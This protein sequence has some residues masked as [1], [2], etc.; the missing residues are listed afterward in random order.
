M[1]PFAQFPFVGQEHESVFLAGILTALQRRQ[2]ESA[3]LFG[4]S[5]PAQRNGK[6]LLVESIGIIATGRIPAAAG[7][8][9]EGEEVRKAITSTLKE[10][11]LVA[12]LDNVVYP[13]DS[14]DLARALTAPLY[15]DRLLGTNSNACL[16]T[17]VMWTATGNNLTFKGDMSMRALLCRIDANL[18]R[19]E[20]RS[21]RIADLRA[22]LR[23][24][25]KQLVA[26]A[27]TILRAYQVAG[28]PRQDV[29]PWGGFDDWSRE[30]REPLS[31]LGMADPCS[32]R[33]QI[34]TNDPE[35]E[36]A[37]DLLRC[38]AEAFH[39]SAKQVRE[40]IAAAPNHAELLNALLMVGARRDNPK[41]IDPRRLGHWLAG[42]ADRVI[43]GRRLV[44]DGKI[45][46]AVAW[47]VS[48]SQGDVPS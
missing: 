47:R 29:R 8:P 6:S 12:H 30:I 21:F 7:V 18:E 34:V 9:R 28:R 37:A 33:E 25:R 16:P 1:E 46:R 23:A 17:N 40:V 3:P 5:A 41:E 39:D 38:W 35:R 22:H 20:E 43:D 2:L 42:N 36:L 31:W 13:L 32:S 44:R 10:G 19:P 11:H 4:F 27:L 24:Q 15:K 48:P 45:H 14:P 26:A